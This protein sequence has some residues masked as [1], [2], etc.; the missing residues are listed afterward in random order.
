MLVALSA[1]AVQPYGVV[2]E[3]STERGKFVSKTICEMG[4][5]FLVVRGV[6]GLSVTQVMHKSPS[7]STPQP[8]KCT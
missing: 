5:V 3:H 4:Y 2:T 6:T 1:Q 7:Y 8:L